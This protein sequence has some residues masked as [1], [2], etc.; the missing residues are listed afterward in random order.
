MRELYLVYEEIDFGGTTDPRVIGV[1][2]N[3]KEV[4]KFV[5]GL[6]WG[7]SVV[8]PDFEILANEVHCIAYDENG[9][10]ISDTNLEYKRKLN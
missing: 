9:V 7:E 10:V 4:D 3:I 5:E 6:Q 2:F 1:F 8:S